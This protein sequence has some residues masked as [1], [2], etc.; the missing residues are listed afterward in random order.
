MRNGV[1][2]LSA[3]AITAVL[4]APTAAGA[5]PVTEAVSVTEH[6]RTGPDKGTLGSLGS[7]LSTNGRYIVFESYARLTKDDDGGEADVFWRDLKTRKTHRMSKSTRGREADAPS[8]FPS[9]SGDGRLVAYSSSATNLVRGDTNMTPCPPREVDEDCQPEPAGDVFVRNVRKRTTRRVSVSSD[10]A[11]GNGSSGLA[12]ISANGRYVVFQ[13]TATNLVEGDVNGHSDIFIRDL[14]LRRTRLG[15]VSSDEKPSDGDCLSSAVSADGRYVAFNCSTTNLVPNDI[16]EADDLF[17]RDL[18]EGTTTLVSVSSE[19]VQGNDFINSFDMSD[20]G[21]VFAFATSASNLVPNDTNRPA[22]PDRSQ[23]G[24]D[25][26]V[27]D[28]DAG[29]TRRVSVTRDGEQSPIDSGN[30]ALSPDGRFVAFASESEQLVPGSDANG[31]LSDVFVRSVKRD[32][33]LRRVS[34]STAGSQGNG[35]SVEPALSRNGRYVSFQSAASN[36][37]RRDRNKTSDVFRR[38]PLTK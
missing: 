13:S 16:N 4:A 9:I 12:S 22:T 23:S 34:V 3:V 19:G 35:Y 2:Q 26:F 38:G 27:R 24:A 28:L 17:V 10:G 6:G 20:D 33:S 11:Q 7:D 30:P 37:V 31:F 8:L 36:L 15:S 25:V 21:R 32:A 14:E 29:T 1:L 18:K 5:A